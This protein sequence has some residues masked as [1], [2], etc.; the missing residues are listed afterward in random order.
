[1]SAGEVSLI[2]LVH[3]SKAFH[4]IAYDKL[5]EKM[6]E[7][8]FSKSFLSW[9]LSYVSNRTQ[10][11]QFDTKKSTTTNSKFGVP[12]GSILGPILFNLYVNDLQNCFNSKAIQYADDTTIYE[13]CKPKDILP[14]ESKLNT[15]LA[16]LTTWASENSLSTNALKTKYIIC[17]TKRLA[18]I[19]NLNHHEPSVVMHDQK[20]KRETVCSLLGVH[21]DQH[22]SWNDQLNDIISSCYSKLATLRKLKHFANFKLRKHLVESL[23]LS[24]IDYNDCI[25]N[26]NETQMKKLQRL[27]LSACSFVYKRYAKMKDILNLKWLPIK[28]RR[29][30]NTLK[31]T[32]K[33]MNMEN[34]PITSS[35][36]TKNT[37]RG[38]R[39][40]GELLLETSKVGLTFQATS[41]ILFNDLPINIRSIRSMDSYSTF[42]NKTKQ[43]LAD[44]AFARNF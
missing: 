20:L 26:L 21:I 22:L 42:C 44:K 16:N 5:I 35:L 11:V 30:F 4:T 28:E 29:E 12:Q 33:A 3:F 40:E 38:L 7:Q 8:G 43:Y 32:Y 37:K 14:K 18:T 10:Y 9:A 2:V 23:I 25:F 36:A 15:S 39:T 27:Q 41:S 24:K 13:H 17:S 6:Y 19:H 34:W 1:M 31:L